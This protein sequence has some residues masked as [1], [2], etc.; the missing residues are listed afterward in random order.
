M[1]LSM[2]KRKAMPKA[3]FA[4]PSKAPKAGS[5][6]IPDRSHAQNALARSAGKAVA[7]KVRAAVKRKYPDMKLSGMMRAK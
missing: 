4:V 5:F 3:E 1:K 7:G 6:P 2:E